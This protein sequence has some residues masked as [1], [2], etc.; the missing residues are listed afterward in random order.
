LRPVYAYDPA[1][2]GRRFRLI[3]FALALAAASI[4][5]SIAVAGTNGSAGS[6]VKWEF[7]RI[8]SHQF[9]LL[10]GRIDPLQRAHIPKALYISCQSKV[11]PSLRF[12]KVT[13]LHTSQVKAELPG[14]GKTVQ[15][16]AVTYR[17]T[18]HDATN[19]STTGTNTSHVIKAPDGGWWLG[20]TLPQYTA[21]KAGHCPA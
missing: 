6:F 12:T 10:W 19:P 1:I 21:F 4:A 13:I 7:D 16:T 15:T 2:A 11:D 9:D 5:A 14:T 18:A 17:V 8:S 3:F 20:L